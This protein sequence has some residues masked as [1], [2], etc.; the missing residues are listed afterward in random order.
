MLW[1]AAGD[2][3]KQYC[4]LF[5]LVS[6][7]KIMN[8]SVSCCITIVRHRSIKELLVKVTSVGVSGW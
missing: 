5:C 3:S 1:Y 6:L 8:Y 2:L 4:I 7:F